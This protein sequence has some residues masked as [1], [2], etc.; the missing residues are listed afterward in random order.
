ML[1]GDGAKLC[2]QCPP[3]PAD[4]KKGF[5]CEQDKVFGVLV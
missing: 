1:P 3:P 2:V 5:A 4:L